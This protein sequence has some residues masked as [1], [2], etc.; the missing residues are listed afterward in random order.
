MDRI[1]ENL[2]TLC[3][4]TGVSGYEFGVA[5]VAADLLRQYTPEV[6]TDDF[7]NAVGIIRSKKENAPTLLLDAHLDEVGMIVTSIDDKGFLK[8]DKCGG[9]D[10]RI[11]AGQ[12]V[13]VHGKKDLHAVVGSTAPHLEKKDERL[14]IGEIKDM[15]IDAGLSKEQAEELIPVGSRVTS[16]FYFDELLN[17]RVSC[18]AQD[19]RAGVVAI[20]ECLELLKGEE[21]DVNLAIEFSGREETGGQG[22]T[23]AAYNLNPDISIAVDVSFAYTPD[24]PKH[25]CFD[26]GQG[27][28]IG[29]AASID[30]RLA[31]QLIEIAKA[32]DIPYQ[33]EVM[34]SSTG[35]NSDK[36]TIL[37]GGIRPAVISIPQRFMHTPIEVI[38]LKDVVAT[39][40]L[41][42]EFIK[43]AGDL[44]VL[45]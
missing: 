8:F 5:K 18:K 12:H 38:D 45:R 37:R 14:K 41:M 10:K 36:I 7:G 30:Q 4:A 25:K 20:L 3:S 26:L 16:R 21:L 13:V 1:K 27:A 32:K 9:L 29:V 2:K 42:A 43:K 17:D 39:A 24:A 11:L 35:T 28:I 31:D 6:H 22:A 19:D 15:Y 44:N 33:I 34:G 23:I 40:R